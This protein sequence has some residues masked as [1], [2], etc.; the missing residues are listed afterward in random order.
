MIIMMQKA[1]NKSF[2][3]FMNAY[4]LHLQLRLT[5]RSK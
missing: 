3:G 5:D 1:L 2:Q 4:S